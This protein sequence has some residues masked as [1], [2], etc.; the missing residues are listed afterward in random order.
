MS[1]EKRLIKDLIDTYSQAGVVG[2]PVHNTSDAILVHFGLA[3]IQILD[4]D[5]KNQVLDRKSVV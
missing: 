4:L 3:L 5:E 2:R 1:A